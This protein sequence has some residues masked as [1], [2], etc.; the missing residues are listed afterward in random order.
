MRPEARQQVSSRFEMFLESPVIGSFKPVLRHG[1]FGFGNLIFDPES[2]ALT[3]V[4]DFGFA[5][6]GD[7]AI[8]FAGVLSSFGEAFLQKCARVYPE[9]KDAWERV[10]FYHSTFALQE[11]LFGIENGDTEAFASGIANYL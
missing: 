11:A 6:L 4:I 5:G 10:R 1:D 8:D 9:I 3:G 2:F 7:A